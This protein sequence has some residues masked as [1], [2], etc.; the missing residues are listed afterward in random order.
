MSN[1]ETYTYPWECAYHYSKQIRN[2]IASVHKRGFILDRKN[3]ISD[4]SKIED[5]RR[6]KSLSIG[7]VANHPK[8]WGVTCMEGIGT[9]YMPASLGYPYIGKCMAW[10]N[11][12]LNSPDNHYSL[13]EMELFTKAKFR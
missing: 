11:P 2:D 9:S 10:D 1:A 3:V 8:K 6:T 5:S 12:T 4:R 7:H 13:S